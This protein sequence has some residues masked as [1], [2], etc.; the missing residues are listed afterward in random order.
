[1]VDRA[2]PGFFGAARR[3]TDL[4]QQLNAGSV[5]LQSVLNTGAHTENAQTHSRMDNDRNG[6]FVLRDRLTGDA[7]SSAHRC[8]ASTYRLNLV[9]IQL[10]GRVMAI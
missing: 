8:C 5:H 1:M 4:C 7:N 9:A 2:D 6:N 3:F 10:G